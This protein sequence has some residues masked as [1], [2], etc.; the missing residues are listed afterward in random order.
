MIK[1][2][3]NSKFLFIKFSPEIRESVIMYDKI[4]VGNSFYSLRALVRCYQAHFTCAIYNKGKW[5]Y[6]D[7][8]KQTVSEFASLELMQKRY[9]FG[10]FFA[11]F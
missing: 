10:W 5:L 4:E 7:D 1:S 11:I 6:V 3:V 2:V 8:L 9:P